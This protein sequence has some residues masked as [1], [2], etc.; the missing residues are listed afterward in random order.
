MVFA[1]QQGLNSGNTASVH[2]RFST[3]TALGSWSRSFI[4]KG[5]VERPT[6]L[7]PYHLH[8]TIIAFCLLCFLVTLHIFHFLSCCVRFCSIVSLRY[9]MWEDALFIYIYKTNPLPL[10]VFLVLGFC[11]FIFW[12]AYIPGCW[13]Q[14]I[15]NT[16]TH[17]SANAFLISAIEPS[18]MLVC[19]EANA[20]GSMYVN[21][22]TWGGTSGDSSSRLSLSFFQCGFSV[23]V[24]FWGGA[25]CFCLWIPSRSVRLTSTFEAQ[26]A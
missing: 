13:R 11:I 24:F 23:V 9:Q 19:Y 12:T 15:T 7:L 14:I 6:G 16:L 25:W 21:T 10:L 5:S 26:L 20:N 3:A 18:S 4:L 22:W 8:Q 2:S 1:G 17:Y